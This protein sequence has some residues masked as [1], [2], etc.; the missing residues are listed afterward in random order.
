MSSNLPPRARHS[1]LIVR[2]IGDETLVYDLRTHHAHALNVSA[3]LIWRSCDGSLA[4]SGLAQRL[5]E[6]TGLPADSEMVQLALRQLSEAD[7]LEAPAGG[8][9]RISRR[10]LAQRLQLVGALALLV[11]AVESVIAP[12]AADAASACSGKGE[13]CITRPCCPPMI[14]NFAGICE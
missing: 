8:E 2:E 12:R 10:E 9:S 3:S 1:D 7:L 13:S 5:S 6:G 11:P 4:E 14:C